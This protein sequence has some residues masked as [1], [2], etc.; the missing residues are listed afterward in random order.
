MTLST[1]CL[2]FR[3]QKVRKIANAISDESALH[4]VIDFVCPRIM[5][6]GSTCCQGSA[7]KSTADMGTFFCLWHLYFCGFW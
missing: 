5:E 7:F 2:S 6:E 1:L 3:L 4:P